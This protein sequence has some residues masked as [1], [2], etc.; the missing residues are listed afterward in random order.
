MTRI[1]ERVGFILTILLVLAATVPPFHALKAHAH[2]GKVTWIPFS[3]RYLIPRDLLINVLLLVPFGFAGPWRR[4]RWGRRLV[5]AAVAGAALSL[6]VEFVQ[7]FSHVRLP[8]ATDVVTNAFGS[9]MGA[10]VPWP[11]RDRSR[12]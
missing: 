11:R 3:E 5:F 2:W 1:A 4:A 9:V 8:T 6:C 10:A 12:A 7:V